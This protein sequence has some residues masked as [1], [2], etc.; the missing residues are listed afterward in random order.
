MNFTVSDFL[1]TVFYSKA[2]KA[3]EAKQYFGRKSNF[4]TNF[5]LKI[6]YFVRLIIKMA[7]VVVKIRICF[8]I[9]L[10]FE[11]CGFS[12]RPTACITCLC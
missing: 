12:Q 4:V 6:G 8:A 10:Q 7:S 3:V 5:D 11:Q 2:E 9:K 1:Q